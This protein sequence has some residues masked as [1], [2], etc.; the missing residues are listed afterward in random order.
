MQYGGILMRAQRRYLPDERPAITHRVE[1]DRG[2]KAF[3]TVGLYSDGTPGEIFIR[4]SKEGS[5]LSGLLHAFCKSVS[6]S[7]QCGVPLKTLA[8][9]FIHTRFEP[10]G[11]TNNPDIPEA[12]S[13]PDY[14]FRWLGTKFLS[15]EDR[16]ELGI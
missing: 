6:L 16:A 1:I 7:L 11:R 2:H 3:I 8:G 14:I 10:S 9:M 15:E 5:T 12:T 13:I 4:I